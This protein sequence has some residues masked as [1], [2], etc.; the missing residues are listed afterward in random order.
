MRIVP[1]STVTLYGGVEIDNGEQLAFSSRSGQT[2][3]FNSK[4]V[5][6]SVPCTMVRKTG[7]LKLEV[8]GSVVSTCNY[9]SFVNPSFDNKTVYA[10]IID[11]DYINNECTEIS[12][13]IDYW[14]TWMFDVTYEESYI[15]RE[16][17]SEDEWDAAEA[18]PY[19]PS[20]FEF[21]T[22]EGLPISKELEKLVY[23]I[24]SDS[25]SDGYRITRALASPYTSTGVLIKFNHVDLEKLDS[26]TT[27]PSNYPSKLLSAY[28]DT[29][30]AQDLGFIHITS[31]MADYLN[32]KHN[33]F[34]SDFPFVATGDYMC[35]PTGW[36]NGDGNAIYPQKSSNY[37]PGC[38]VIYDQY[39]ADEANNNGAMAQFFQMMTKWENVDGIIDMSII[40]ND[41]MLL[42]GTTFDGTY[43][44]EAGQSVPSDNVVNKKLMRYPYNYLRVMSPNG[45]V[46]EYQYEHFSSVVNG[47]GTLGFS[48]ILDISDRPVLLV[49]PRGYKYTGLSELYGQNTN[50]LEAI[51]FDQ[52]PTMP[53]TIDAFTA[54]VAAVANSTIANRTFDAAADMAATDTSTN[55]VAQFIATAGSVLGQVTG[56]S[57]AMS[58]VRVNKQH[59][60]FGDKTSVSGLEGAVLG[61]AQGVGAAASMYSRGASMEMDRQKFEQASDRWHGADLALGEAGSNAITTQWSL[62]KPAYACD[63]YEP[64][65]GC[66]VS[67]FNKLSFCDIV[68]LRV[69]LSDEIK[70]VYDKY[71]TLY[72]YKS[73]RCGIPRVINYVTGDSDTP[74]WMSNGGKSITYIKTMDLKVIYSMLPVASYIKAM[75]DSGVRFIKGD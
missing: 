63:K 9:L 42:A 70:N 64:S 25:D 61:I 59:T 46:K 13:A 3:Y 22:D 51:Y 31:D 73:G 35:N 21:R 17:L 1:D 36:V 18:N 19:D 65:N 29:I 8:P 49:V 75:F 56:L 15:D 58:G 28:L 7:T 5:R 52:F 66:G 44:W 41:I 43:F 26:G 62:T 12:Y 38:C 68:L 57:D 14:Q 45:D 24:G 30:F 72:G 55:R 60:L 2:A 10:R 33:A 23:E 11:Y 16:H 6:Q 54:Q 32:A 27:S 50:I 47:D 4:L 67:N 53:Y 71:F 74:H 48:L 37:N 34:P 20:I 40:P 69:S 39:G